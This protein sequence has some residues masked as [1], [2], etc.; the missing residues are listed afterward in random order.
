MQ[1]LHRLLA[2][3]ARRGIRVTP[4]GNG[5]DNRYRIEK[6]TATGGELV[7]GFANSLM[8][9]F[10]GPDNYS[11]ESILDFSLVQPLLRRGG[12]AR[13]MERLTISERSLLANV[14][15]MQH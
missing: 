14:R 15:Q 9:Q 8:W 6:L 1:D 7:V 2:D 10:A 4:R 13:V 12:R 3:C 11:A 5:P